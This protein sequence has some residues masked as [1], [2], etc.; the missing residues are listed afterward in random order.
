MYL[1]QLGN[2]HWFRCAGCGIDYSISEDKR[3]KCEEEGIWIQCP[4]CY[5][6]D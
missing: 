4:S 1:G 5:I 3:Q 6:S 2:L